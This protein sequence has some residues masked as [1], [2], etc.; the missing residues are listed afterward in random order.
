LNVP[1]VSEC[2]GLKSKRTHKIRSVA[3]SSATGKSR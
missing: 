3:I 2:L 1:V